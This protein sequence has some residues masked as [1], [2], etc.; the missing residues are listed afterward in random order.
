V[1]SV[2]AATN[3]VVLGSSLVPIGSVTTD[4]RAVV[5]GALFLA[6]AGERFDGHDFAEAAIAGGAAAVLVAS[7]RATK[8]SPRIEVA[9]TGAALLDIAALRRSELDVPVVAV[10]GSTGKTSTKDILAHVL[11]G[12]WASPASYNNEI[13]VPLTVLGVPQDARFLVAEVGSRGRGHIAWL[14]PAVRP[15]VAVITNLGVVHLETFGTVETLA[16]AKWELVEGLEPGGTAVLPAN[17]PRLARRHGGRTITFGDERSADVW[18]DDVQVDDAGRSTFR[19]RT[20]T[21]ELR[22]HMAMAGAHQPWNAV[23]ATAAALALG[24]DLDAVAAGLERA[25]GSPGRMEIHQGSVT[26]VN[27]AYNANPDSMEAA[28]RTVASMPG[29]HIAV[30]G[31][32]AELG[33]VAVEEHARMGRLVRELGFAAVVVI[34]DEPGLAEAAGPIA[35]RVEDTEEARRVLHNFLRDGDV[36]LVKASHAVGLETL[37]AELVEEAKA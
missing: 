28:L 8:V 33:S 36:V 27:D 16:D 24:V 15:H 5:P 26:V 17:E 6:V 22:V 32:M 11:E 30:L 14:M 1:G 18:F 25:V 20:G 31:L 4:S 10:T 3:G 37:A 12:A 7:G 35:R 23:A 29:R 34:G 2:A 19:L 21:G 13:G 9:D